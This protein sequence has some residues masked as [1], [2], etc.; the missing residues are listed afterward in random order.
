MNRRDAMISYVLVVCALLGGLVSRAAETIT[1]SWTSAHSSEPGK[2]EFALIHHQHGHSSS[3]ESTWPVT[4]F[5]GLDLS[6]PGKQEVKFTINR[7]AGRFDC[8]GYVTN[9]EG[10]G[11]FHFTADAKFPSEMSALGFQGIDDEKQFSWRF[12]M[13]VSISPGK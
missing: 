1:G 3:H 8:E 5:A 10:A 9:G 6:K 2:V 4:A 11:V 12:S 7:D 13:S